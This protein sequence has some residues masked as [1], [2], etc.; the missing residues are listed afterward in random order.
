MLTFE[1][2]KPETG[3][4]VEEMFSSYKLPVQKVGY[5]VKADDTYIGVIDYTVQAEK[6]MLQFLLVHHDYQGYGYGTNAYYTFEEMMKEEGVKCIEVMQ[7]GLSE[8]VQSLLGQLGFTVNNN[9]YIK[10]I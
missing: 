3:F 9:V 7:K 5:C 10:Q 4:V 8:R 2:V 6:A 1:A